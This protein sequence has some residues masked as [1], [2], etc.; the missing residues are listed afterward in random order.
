MKYIKLFESW[1]SMQKT[2][3]HSDNK[4]KDFIENLEESAEQRYLEMTKGLPIGKY[5]CGCGR[6]TSDNE[7][8][9]VGPKITLLQRYL[10]KH[11]RMKIPIPN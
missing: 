8:N 6:V 10:R 9:F 7:M 3:G 11:Q 4:M 1:V 2:S 5:R